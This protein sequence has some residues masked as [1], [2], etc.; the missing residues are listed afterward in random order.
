TPEA[1]RVLRRAAELAPSDSTTL[2]HLDRALLKAGNKEEAS[3]AMARLRALGPN[4]SNF[5]HPAG[6]VEFLSLSPE[7]QYARYRAG[8]ERTVQKNPNNADAQVQFLKLSLGDGKMDEAAAVSRQILALKPSPAV[9]ADA[10][11]SLLAAEQYL[12]AKEFL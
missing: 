12:L 6:L 1:V 7:E 8:V 5:A 3:A 10:A 11:E 9:L 2:M 4:R